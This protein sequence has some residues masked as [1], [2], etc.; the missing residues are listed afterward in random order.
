M[1]GAQAKLMSGGSER[2]SGS[3]LTRKSSKKEMMSTGLTR[4]ELE[5]LRRY[6]DQLA[7]LDDVEGAI[8]SDVFVRY[9]L[10]IEF[11]K[12]GEARK[13]FSLFDRDGNGI[14]SFD[15]LA[16][17]TGLIAKGSNS[18]KLKYAFRLYDLEGTGYLDEVDVTNIITSSI[19]LAQALDIEMDLPDGLGTDDDVT[20]RHVRQI[21]R[22][23]DMNHDNVI[24]EDEFLAAAMN[25]KDLR[26]I[27]RVF[28][29]LKHPRKVSANR[30][31]RAVAANRAIAAYEVLLIV[32]ETS[33]DDDS[34]DGW[35]DDNMLAQMAPE[36]ADAALFDYYFGRYVDKYEAQAATIVDPA[37]SGE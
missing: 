1:G 29:H 18:D 26:R 20:H 8:S 11:K 25:N 19:E 2:G 15:E 14:I 22:D 21:F 23:A 16:I 32:S 33:S 12:M 31:A 34:A 4:R 30:E 37:G 5:R 6:F 10:N 28:D 27:V 7:E 3:V 17:F 13:L 24:R 36:E 9:C 35:I